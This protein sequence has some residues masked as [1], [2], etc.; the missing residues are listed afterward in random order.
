M[1]GGDIL[2]R[3]GKGEEGHGA[4][5]EGAYLKGRRHRLEGVIHHM[6]GGRVIT[7]SKR[8]G[9]NCRVEVLEIAVVSPKDFP[10]RA[11]SLIANSPL[12]GYYLHSQDFRTLFRIGGNP[13]NSGRLYVCICVPC[14]HTHVHMLKYNNSSN[15]YHLLSA[16]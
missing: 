11:I 7:K 16:C 10:S 9:E 8:L 5:V 6:R 15:G 4:T 12:L 14:V 1:R 13:E 2:C 3:V